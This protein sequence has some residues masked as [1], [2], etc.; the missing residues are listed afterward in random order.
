MGEGPSLLMCLWLLQDEGAVEGCLRYQGATRELVEEGRE[1][2]RIFQAA[3]DRF[4]R[5]GVWTRYHRDLLDDWFDSDT[6]IDHDTIST[7]MAFATATDLSVVTLNLLSQMASFLHGATMIIGFSA[8][9]TLDVHSI[10]LPWTRSA[11]IWKSSRSTAM[12]P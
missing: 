4:A 1:M 11:A 8:P 5:T 12:T 6:N 10:P 3:E 7:D 2:S 9:L